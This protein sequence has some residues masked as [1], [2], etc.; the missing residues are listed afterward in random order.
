MFDDL[1][2]F[3]FERD[4][5][6]VLDGCRVMFMDEEGAVRNVLNLSGIYPEKE[7]CIVKDILIRNGAMFILTSDSI[8]SMPIPEKE[9]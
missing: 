6:C 2:S 5:L 8:L 4:T 3:Q 7:G 9:E 1:R